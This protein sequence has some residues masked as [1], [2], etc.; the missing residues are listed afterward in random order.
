[1][2]KYLI[3]ISALF[4]IG[5]FAEIE[6]PIKFGSDD[7]MEK[8]S[9]IIESKKTC[10][11]ASQITQ[12]CAMG[13]SMDVH[14]VNSALKICSKRI[15]LS[16]FAQKSVDSANRLCIKKYAKSEGT[17]AMSARAFCL[18]EVTKLYDDLL[19]PADL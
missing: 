4:S 10:Y 8:V 14:F 3:M 15:H 9:T 18:L 11:E 13:S 1:M 19:A 17:L 7:Y 12:S 16:A 5:A 6:C 2:K